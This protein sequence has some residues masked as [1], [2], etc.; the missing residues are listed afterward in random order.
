MGLIPGETNQCDVGQDGTCCNLR[1][2]QKW[3]R[4]LSGKK[5]LVDEKTHSLQGWSSTRV[6]LSVTSLSHSGASPKMMWGIPLLFDHF[7]MGIIHF[8]LLLTPP[9]SYFGSALPFRCSPFFPAYA[10]TD[11]RAAFISVILKHMQ[12]V[13][14]LKSRA[15]MG[16]IQYLTN[17]GLKCLLCEKIDFQ[18]CKPLGLAH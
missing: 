17:I 1:C 13:W 6:V 16:E 2:C 10:S 15:L 14:H 18:F 8:H 11:F 5:T 9:C 7:A 3:Q 4:L 12:C